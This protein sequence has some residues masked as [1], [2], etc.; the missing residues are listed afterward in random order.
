[1]GWKKVLGFHH[2][3]NE[4][5]IHQ[6]YATLEVH[7]KHEKLIWMMG[8]CR[9]EVAYKDLT[10]TVRLDYR[11]MKRVKLMVELPMLLVGEM[12]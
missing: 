11:K 12:P 3:W 9:V 1:M 4:T 6:F 8:T 5:M 7:P 2:G 10:A